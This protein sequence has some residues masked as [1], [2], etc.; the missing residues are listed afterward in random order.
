M[1]KKNRDTEALID[2]YNAGKDILKFT[3]G[4]SQEQ[5]ELNKE[6]SNA[7]LYS[8]QIIG[9]AT[10]K[11]SPEFRQDNKHI[12]WR[13]MAGMRDKIVHDYNEINFNLVWKVAKDEIP[14]LLEQI[15]GF[16]P[17]K[18]EIAAPNIYE[19]YASES[20]KVGLARTKEIAT[21]AFS[22]GIKRAEII[23]MLSQNDSAYQDLLKVADSNTAEKL[24]VKKAEMESKLKDNLDQ[25]NELNEKKTK[26]R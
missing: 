9:E 8:I 14:R 25:T 22:N 21:K 23:E 3:S 26:K 17:E 2:I 20:N 13:K 6:K 7:T 12:Q 24:I 19:Q 1:S 10:K 4:I 5:L 11:L 18:P 15:K 16:L